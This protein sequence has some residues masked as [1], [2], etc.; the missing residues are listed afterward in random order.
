MKK[1]LL[2][3]I[4]LSI[5]F[6]AIAQHH[7]EIKSGVNFSSFVF[8]DSKS[9][10]AKDLTHVFNNYSAISYEA[11]LGKNKRHIVRPELGFRQSGAR[12]IKDKTKYE[13]KF[14]YLDVNLTYMFKFLGNDNYGLH[15]GAGPNLGFLLTGEQ[16]IGEEYYDV[17][18]ENQIKILDVGL[19]FLANAQF[20]VSKNIFVSVEYRY[21]LGLLNI[22]SDE[23]QRTR[24]T[25]HYILAGLLFNL[26][27]KNKK[28]DESK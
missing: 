19:N 3:L 4:T 7:I 6:A 21:G 1:T 22:E 18:D 10:K 12:I 15:V 25:N 24:S 23:D 28:E 2:T 13:W 16:S 5:C 26:N 20:K 14:N 9:I 17:I 11:H 8:K 27:L